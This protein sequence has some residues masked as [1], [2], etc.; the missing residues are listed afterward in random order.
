MRY[1]LSADIARE[2]ERIRTDGTLP[3]GFETEL[4]RTF[5][6][7]AADPSALEAEAQAAASSLAPAGP[8]GGDARRRSRRLLR[9]VDRRTGHRL[10]ELERRSVREGML[11]AERAVLSAHVAADAAQRVLAGTAASRAL[12]RATGSEAD[13]IGRA[14]S[15]GLG[16][17]LGAEGTTGDEEVDGLLLEHLASAT[18]RVL[19]TESGSGAFVKRLLEMGIE[20]TGADPAHGTRRR[21]SLE[22]LAL[23]RRASLGGLVL[24][25]VPDRCTPARARALARLAASRLG[26]G[27]VLAVVS[28][29]PRVREESDPVADDLAPGRPLHPV[30]WCHLAARFAL[31]QAAV[32]ESQSGRLYL[33]TATRQP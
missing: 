22:A 11:L 30:T 12:N 18:G 32:R 6:A 26:P 13:G 27:G 25:S 29:H 5:E 4:R 1:G 31:V 21:G 3:D 9:A 14:G 7:I 2:A 28:E 19:H 15:G 16:D 24:S 23:S 8:G 20:A 33:V 17:L 10:S